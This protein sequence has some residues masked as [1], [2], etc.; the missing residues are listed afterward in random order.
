MS[1]DA[2]SYSR[3]ECWERC[4]LQFKLKFIDNI[5]SPG[6]PAMQRGNEVHLAMARYVAAPDT[7]GLAMPDVVT[8][9][10]QMQ[11]VNAIRD[12]DDK[13]VEQKWALSAQWRSTAYFKKPGKAP[14]WLRLILDVA[15]LYEDMEGEAID[16]KTGRQ[17]EVNQD[18]ME[19]FGL[20]F[21]CY[22]QPAVKVTT[23]LVYLDEGTEVLNQYDAKDKEKLQ[24][25][26]EKKVAPMFADTTFLP[27]PNDKCR[28]CD[29]SKSKGGQCRFG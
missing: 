11:L 20:G 28:F 24:A 3:F 12:H 8:N 6:T 13:L 21:L 1:V 25:K 23:R 4:P 27:R 18:Q 7:M 10:F 14:P 19:L 29:F 16:W 22:F 26:W 2:W 5:K 15:V 17:Y 9:P